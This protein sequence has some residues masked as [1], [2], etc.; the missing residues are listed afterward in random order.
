MALFFFSTGKKITRGKKGSA[1]PS[2][3]SETGRTFIF[4]F[5][6]L[7]N[8][9]SPYNRAKGTRSVLRVC[10]FC[11]LPLPLASQAGMEPRL[12]VWRWAPGA[13]IQP[14]Q[15][16]W[17]LWWQN[18]C[19]SSTVNL[20]WGYSIGN[21]ILWR[22]SAKYFMNADFEQAGGKKMR[23]KELVDP[24]SAGRPI[25]V[26]TSQMSSRLIWDN[27]YFGSAVLVA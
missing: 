27:K 5:S 23:E 19:L 9:V 6:I 4:L 26:E 17:F 24:H 8:N 21:I 2:W 25:N 22:A 14:H 12:S 20:R 16:F 1:V 10:S 13:V 18:I 3:G 15:L 11:P 7:K